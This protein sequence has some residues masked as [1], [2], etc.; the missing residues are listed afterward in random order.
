MWLFVWKLL[1][2]LL[3]LFMPYTLVLTP[4]LSHLLTS[5][6]QLCRHSVKQ[7]NNYQVKSSLSTV[8]FSFFCILYHLHTKR[9]H[10][11][12]RKHLRFLVDTKLNLN[13]QCATAARKANTVLGCTRQQVRKG[14]P[15][16]LLSTLVSLHLGCC[17]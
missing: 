13:Q 3:A 1:F 8:I 17:V 7:I 10:Q 14:D 11:F 15:S 9:H 5:L 2:Q 16:P 6:W 4:G 12:S